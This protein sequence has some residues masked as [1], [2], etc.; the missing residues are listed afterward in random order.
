MPLW[1]KTYEI[2]ATGPNCGLIEL[3][4]DAMS[5]NEIH[6]KANGVTLL[7]YFLVAH[8]KVHSKRFQRAQ[9]NFAYSLAGY[10]LV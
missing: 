7:D 2:I 10:S 6:Q 3:I 9:K 4:N 1:L 8:G 5:I